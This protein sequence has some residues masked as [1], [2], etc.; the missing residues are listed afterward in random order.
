M[1]LTDI[2][3]LERWLAQA[4]TGHEIVFFDPTDNPL[5]NVDQAANR[6]AA[7]GAVYNQLI[8]QQNK[9]RV[10]LSID[11]TGRYIATRI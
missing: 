8:E 11:G 2:K 3:L 10:Y 4:P 7:F 9:R 5:R 1:M 6:D